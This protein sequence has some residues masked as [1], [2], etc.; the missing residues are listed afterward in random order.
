MSA[1]RL[2]VLIGL[3]LAVIGGAFWLSSQRTLRRDPDYGTPV[4][5]G[6]AA[7][8]D[9]IVGLRMV[10]AGNH[11]L[12]TLAHRDGRWYVEQTGYPAD[13]TKVRRA[14]IAL[15]DLHV[16]EA[17][18]RDP[19]RYAELAV[20][21]VAAPGAASVR[22]ELR[23]LKEP[24][25]LLV[26]RAAGTQGTYVRVPGAGQALEARPGLDLARTPHDWLARTIVDVAPARVQAVE[27][28]RGDAPPWRAVRSA[29]D[30]AHF[31]VPDLPRGR[32]L[33]SLGAADAAANVLGN[34]EFEEVRRAGAPAGGH[35]HRAVVRC[36]D[37]LVVT[38]EGHATGSEHWIT[39]SASVDPALAARFPPAAGQQAPGDEQ[40]RGEAERLTATAR[41]W[42]YR[43]AGYRFD[44]LFRARDELLRH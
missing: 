38:L 15:G 34:L 11:A 16:V 12:V 39:A 30:A 2:F 17:K 23:G 37:G 21:D 33:T 19:A 41:G 4:L 14:L 27:V 42:E 8:L 20:E 5:P 26:G 3:A 9:A 32:E 25:A 13:A 7:S 6:L 43:I 24:V 36:F 40:V 44:A 29:R 1:R 22:I 28:E 18:T 10:G 35:P 31:D